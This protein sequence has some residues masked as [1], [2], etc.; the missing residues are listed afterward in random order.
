[1]LTTDNKKRQ[2]TKTVRRNKK[3]WHAKKTIATHATRHPLNPSTQLP[4][5]SPTHLRTRPHA[6]RST[7]PATTNPATHH[8]MYP[9]YLPTYPATQST[10]QPASHAYNRPPTQAIQQASNQPNNQ[11]AN[12]PHS[13]YSQTSTHSP[14]GPPAHPP[15]RMWR[16]LPVSTS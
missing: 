8:P 9:F 6:H 1:M 7:C 3:Q 16:A 5:Y 14:I 4:I 15:I 13:L 12:Q 11:R 2:Q 10:A